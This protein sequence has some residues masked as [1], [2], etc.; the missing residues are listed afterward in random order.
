[1]EIFFLINGTKARK[2]GTPLQEGRNLALPPKTN[3]KRQFQGQNA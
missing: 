1:M 3:T 2:Y